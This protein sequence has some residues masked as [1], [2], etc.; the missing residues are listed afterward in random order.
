M[1]KF[2]ALSLLSMCEENNIA[3]AGE[4]ERRVR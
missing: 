1:L 2:G 3:T 4:M